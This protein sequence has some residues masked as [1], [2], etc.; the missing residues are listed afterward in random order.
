[1]NLK[2]KLLM[3]GYVCEHLKALNVGSGGGGADHTLPSQLSRIEFKQLDHLDVYAPALEKSK[4]MKWSTKTVN[5]ILE[6]IRNFDF[7]DYDL[8]FMFDVVEHLPKNDALK[9]LG[10]IEHALI[11][12]PIEKIPMKDELGTPFQDHLSRWTEQ[13][14][15]SLGFRT[16][17]LKNYHGSFDAMWA[18]K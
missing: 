12:V 1:M 2:S 3:S 14:F 10:K 13:D 18:E 6:D 7:S 17:V 5:F 15:I 11:F 9:I 16:E 4:G 8:L